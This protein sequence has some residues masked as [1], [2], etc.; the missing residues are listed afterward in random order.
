MNFKTLEVSTELA[1]ESI[2]LG[3]YNYVAKNANFPCGDHEILIGTI[4]ILR[5]H[6]KGGWGG[7]KMPIF[8]YFQY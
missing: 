7:Q 3:C 6:L 4:H 5:Q 8:D 1:D 2:F